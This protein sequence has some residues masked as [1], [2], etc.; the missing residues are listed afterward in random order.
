MLLEE[1]GIETVGTVLATLNL[2]DV[3]QFNT[4]VNL[5][6]AFGL[7]RKERFGL[8]LTVRG[9]TALRT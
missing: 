5:L 2:T 8:V 1:A 3:E 9:K 6:I 4:Q 7:I